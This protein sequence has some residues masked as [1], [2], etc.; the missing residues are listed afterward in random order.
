[1]SINIVQF[2]EIFQ[3]AYLQLQPWQNSTTRE[4]LTLGC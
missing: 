4:D 3:G 1:M 2:N